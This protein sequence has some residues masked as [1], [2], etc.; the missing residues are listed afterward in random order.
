MWLI[1]EKTSLNLV[2][3]T[4]SD[5]MKKKNFFLL[6]MEHSSAT[7]PVD[8]KNIW[9]LLYFLHCTVFRSIECCTAMNDHVT[10]DSICNMFRV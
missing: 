4:A 8:H 1:A 10:N 6:V 5:H 7:K 9:Q 2:A 3:V